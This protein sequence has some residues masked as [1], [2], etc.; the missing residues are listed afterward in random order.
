[1]SKQIPPNL[2]HRD[3]LIFLLIVALVFFGASISGVALVFLIL[4]ITGSASAMSIT[5]AL[6]FLPAIFVPIIATFVDRVP[7][8]TPLLV[9]FFLNGVILM[10]LCIGT[11]LDILD[12]DI[13]YLIVLF[14]GF[15]E[16]AYIPTAQ[17]LI[18]NLVM[19]K[20]LEK[21]NGLISIASQSMAFLGLLIGGILV[22]IIGPS[23]SI[24]IEGVCFF[25]GGYLLV[26]IR[27]P[28]VAASN[29]TNT[30]WT[31]LC[32]GLKIIKT[33]KT[34]IIII[35]MLFLTNV[36]FT[37]LQILLPLHMKVL[38]ENGAAGYGICMALTMIGMVLGNFIITIWG[39]KLSNL[40]T[41][42]IGWFILGL[43]Y[44]GLSILNKFNFILF[45]MLI[46]G[47]GAA[48][49]NTGTIVFLQKMIPSHVRGRVTGVIIKITQA[50]TPIMM[51]F[52]SHIIENVTVSQVFFTASLIIYG[53]T[54]V[55]YK[56]MK[57][58]GN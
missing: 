26:L 47:F 44:T 5:L 28:N 4:D 15:I 13:I 1:M 49:V 16:T 36:F 52:L 51:L 12:I 33:S 25:I 35:I 42:I 6:K 29:T 50:G 57:I 3:F 30:F 22:T 54:I 55:W 38:G 31:D 20:N 27:L 34:V 8:K 56:L 58:M 18:P 9:G 45:W 48:F 24:A 23:F 46:Y 40:P 53:F 19:V 2:F 43:C 10:L 14:S 41:I 39:S 21:G 11:R 32:I 17:I 7:L 37:P